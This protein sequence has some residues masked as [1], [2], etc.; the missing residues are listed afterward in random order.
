MNKS[1]LFE[2]LDTNEGRIS[3]SMYPG[4]VISDLLDDVQQITRTM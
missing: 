2:Y 1:K 3:N 4:T